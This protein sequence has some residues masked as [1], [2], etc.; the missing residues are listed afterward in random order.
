MVGA[1]PR[2]IVE[3]MVRS[4]VAALVVSSAVIPVIV[5]TGAVVLHVHVNT[6]LAALAL[7]Y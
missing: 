2:S 3:E 1:A 5:N 7:P 4:R 6:L